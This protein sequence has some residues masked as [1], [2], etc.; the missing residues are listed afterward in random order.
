MCGFV[1][2][3]DAE[4]FQGKHSIFM[5]F[6]MKD[7]YRRGPDSQNTW[8]SDSEKLELGF[9]RLA[10]RDL[11]E[12]G[13]QPMH[14]KDGR[15]TI[16]YNGETYN[17]NDLA[18]FS[19][20][21]KELL[22]GT[23]DT[24]IILESIAKIGLMK[25]LER[26]DGIFAI[27]LFDSFENKL[28]LVRDR[29]GVKPLYMGI[30]EGVIVFSSHY[31]HITS[32]E[33]FRNEEIKQSSLENYFRFGFI[34]EGEG[35]IEH[36]YF[37]PHG[38][39]TTIDLNDFNWGWSSFLETNNRTT[40]KENDLFDIS[41]DVIESQ[42]ISD[43]PV[44][45]FLSGGVDSTFITQM[46][47][48]I[49]P[50]ISGVTLGVNDIRY[51]ESEEA[52]QTAKKLKINHV[53]AKFSENELHQILQDYRK[54]LCEPL[55]DPSSI[56]TLKVCE[57]AKRSVTV[58]LSG[59]GADEL[60]WGYPRFFDSYRLTRFFEIP[61]WRRVLRVF[62]AKIFARRTNLSLSLLR[63]KNFEE[64]YLNKQ[65]IPGNIIW[66]KELFNKSLI[67]QNPMMY[68][69][70]EKND[71]MDR[72]RQIEFNIHLQRVLLKVDR[73]SMFHSI[74]VRTPFLS[75]KFIDLSKKYSYDQCVDGTVG[76]IPLR[77]INSQCTLS[78]LNSG[79]TKKGFSPPI[80]MWLRNEL[81]NEVE[82]VLFKIPKELGGLL[83]STYIKKV[84]DEHQ[85]GNRD[86]SWIIWSL[87]SL[88]VWVN[89]K[90][91]SC[92]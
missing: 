88:F 67:E 30:K 6:A 11:S 53:T 27:A 92:E 50:T 39:V 49:D 66:V 28:F 60:F 73:A 17:T 57:V 62:G 23:S 16:V 84:W 32:H 65:G 74:E 47:A 54:S 71:F 15:Y 34:Q 5:D 89:D 36:T 1:G 76:K 56:L 86:N 87:F 58:V 4:N 21:E 82:E 20:I 85:V 18:Q 75:N 70:T 37:L 55:A 19:G 45:S 46:S 64:Y 51:D 48:Q 7:L 81:K 40:I 79:N 29:A 68:H 69:L 12:F 38:F 2:I 13:T 52:I 35:I 33:I 43:V 41:K 90:M 42:L 3:F 26:M 44:G 24:E 78:D 72:A 91:K 61:K 8:K 83:N 59:D 77:E 80:D 14:S 22:L 10:I 9:A 63:F 31:H 25:V